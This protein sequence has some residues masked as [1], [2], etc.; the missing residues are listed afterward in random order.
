MFKRSRVAW[1][2]SGLFSAIIVLVFAGTAYFNNLDDR[3]QALAAAR[4]V[5]KM[6]ARTIL[7]SLH[8][9]MTTGDVEGIK[10]LMEG[11]AQDNPVYEDIQLISHEGRIVASFG[12]SDDSTIAQESW[13]CKRCHIPGKENV[14]IADEGSLDRMVEAADGKRALSVITLISVGETCG[15]TECHAPAANDRPLGFLKSDYS[16]EKLD[17]LI[18]QHS[19]K[20]TIGVLI[21][22]LLS[23][24]A[25]W[26]AIQRLVVARIRVLTAGIKRVTHHDFDFR[27]SGGGNDEFAELASEFNEMTRQ[28]SS[29]VTKLK[30]TR[31][32]L[33]G[34][35]EDSADII[36]TVD[37]KGLI[38]KFNTGAERTLGY[39]REEVI[40]KR[41]EM[42]F[43]DPRERD[44]AIEQLE[45]TDHVVNYETH[46]L[47]KDGRV[48]NVILTL[49]RLRRRDGTQVGTYGISKDITREKRL[50][51]QLL[52]SERMALLG[53]ALTGIQHSVKNLLNVLKGGSYM[54]KTG[55]AKDDRELLNEGWEMVQEGITHMTEFSKSMLNF[56]KERKLDL[57]RV[58][59]TELLKK[60]YSMSE[61][62]FR[63]KGVSLILD[64][65]DNV[66]PV[67]CDRELIHSVVMDLL[68]NSLDACSWKEYSENMNPQVR[69]SVRGAANEEYVSVEVIDNGEGIPEEVRAKLFTPFFSTKKK[70]G[71]GMG[72]ALT[73]RVVSSH[74]GKII[75]ESEPGQ[76][77]AFRVLL[78]ISGRVLGEEEYDV[79]E[80]VGR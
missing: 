55:L 61:A 15:G 68:S 74:G 58:D 79:E 69:L 11:I 1:K 33:Q 14:Q 71:T 75:V 42:L 23:M 36:I 78:P 24:V 3:A 41:I 37:P 51:R 53:Q 18:V 27:F 72:L 39:K 19:Y 40:G 25:A 10:S 21:G 4:D 28:L 22:V 8:R 20:T 35:V 66:P 9:F 7:H 32:Y 45:G 65:V 77:A 64:E 59:L 50:Q 17:D 47:T 30:R 56:A 43:S 38:R 73:A 76:G 44:V 57:S 48:R 31:E 52:Q 63:E 80:S 62:R 2:V 67:L 60:I 34:I 6:H 5:S 70:K 26:F 16:I 54:V 46:F 12:G 49:S 29:S 13:P